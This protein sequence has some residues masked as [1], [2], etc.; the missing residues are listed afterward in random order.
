MLMLFR[1]KL[2]KARF[3][4]SFSVNIAILARQKTNT[5]V[6]LNETLDIM[7][8]SNFSKTIKY[9]VQSNRKPERNN[10]MSDNLF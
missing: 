1:L 8:Q 3:F 10:E 2:E 7:G 4:S 6:F 5:L 9:I